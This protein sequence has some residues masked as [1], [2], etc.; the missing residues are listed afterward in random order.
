MIGIITDSTK[1]NIL[2]NDREKLKEELD[3]RKSELGLRGMVN[4]RNKNEFQ[5][6]EDIKQNSSKIQE[7]ME[8]AKEIRRKK[9]LEK[10]KALR[11]KRMKEAPDVYF[12]NK[13]RAEKEAFEKRKIII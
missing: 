4:L 13:R 12:R 3:A 9:N 2:K 1:E 7:E 11:E 10:K 8:E 5:Q 6:L